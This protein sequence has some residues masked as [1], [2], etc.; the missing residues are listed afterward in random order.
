VDD[1]ASFVLSLSLS[2]SLSLLLNPNPNIVKHSS[3]ILL[4]VGCLFL[5]AEFSLMLLGQGIE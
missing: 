3:N 5:G 1:D 2:L 4:L